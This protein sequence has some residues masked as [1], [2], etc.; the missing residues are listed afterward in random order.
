MDSSSKPEPAARADLDALL[1]AVGWI[2]QDSRAFNPTAGRGI[3]LLEVPLKTG[4]CDALPR[5]LRTAVAQELAAAEPQLLILDDVPVNTDPVRQER[6]LDVLTGL[7]I[8]L[9]TLILTCHPDR[10]RGVGRAITI[11]TA[12]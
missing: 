3:A 9:Q 7:S 2:V 8:R 6:I 5:C 1:S 10:Y 12:S 4:P 11:S